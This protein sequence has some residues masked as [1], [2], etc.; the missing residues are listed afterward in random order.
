MFDWLKRKPLRSGTPKMT[1]GKVK[2]WNDAKGYGFI[3]PA[4]GGEDI[5]VH[6]S[7]LQMTG[8][9]T[10]KEGQ[11][12]KFERSQAKN[13]PQA[14]SVEV[15]PVDSTPQDAATDDSS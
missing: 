6:F 14:T 3:I 4:E 11:Q 9:K 7:S 5:F 15:L 12:V 2:W 10:L 13:G 8:F 1:T